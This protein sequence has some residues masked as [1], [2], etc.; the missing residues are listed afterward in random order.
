MKHEKA[1]KPIGILTA[2]LDDMSF[3][4]EENPE[5]DNEKPFFL[6]KDFA[7]PFEEV[8]KIWVLNRAPEPDYEFIEC[9]VEKAGLKEYDAYGFF[10]YNKGRYISDRF[11]FEALD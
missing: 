2:N 8:L 9:L 1:E 11:Y 3:G 5:Y 6:R 4:F 7:I 10:K